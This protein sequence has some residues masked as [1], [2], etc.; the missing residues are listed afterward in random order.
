M[1]R[2]QRATTCKGQLF[3]IGLLHMAKELPQGRPLLASPSWHRRQSLCSPTRQL[4]GQ[5]GFRRVGSFFGIGRL[6]V[7]LKPSD[8]RCGVICKASASTSGRQH[9]LEMHIMAPQEAP[10]VINIPSDLPWRLGPGDAATAIVSTAKNGHLQITLQASA[11]PHDCKKRV[12]V[13]GLLAA[14]LC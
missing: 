4:A 14:Q 3:S 5:C 11:A 13:A 7:L 1:F 9:C 2:A 6:W 12:R 10:P 8:S